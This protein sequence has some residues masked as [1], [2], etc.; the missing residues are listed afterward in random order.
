MYDTAPEYYTPSVPDYNDA[1]SVSTGLSTESSL[2]SDTPQ[3]QPQPLIY[4][5]ITIQ[6]RG[7][8]PIFSNPRGGHN[9]HTPA[10]NESKVSTEKFANRTRVADVGHNIDWTGWPLTRPR[11]NAK[12]RTPADCDCGLVGNL[13]LEL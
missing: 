12:C 4:H 8:V 6:R 7:Y 1:V 5:C 3:P 2:S 11:A 10:G 13:V 9:Y